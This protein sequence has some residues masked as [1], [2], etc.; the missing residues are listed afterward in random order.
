[1]SLHLVLEQ[2]TL[3]LAQQL[4]NPGRP[5]PWLQHNGEIVDWDLKNQ[6]KQKKQKSKTITQGST[7][8]DAL[9]EIE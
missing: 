3:I 9:V 8:G 7:K 6:I 4:I 1:M 2:D 5:L